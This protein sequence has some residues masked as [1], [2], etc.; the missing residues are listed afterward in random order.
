[1]T[2]TVKERVVLAPNPSPLTGPGTNTILLGEREVAVI[3]P[4]PADPAHL[5]AVLDAVG[6]GRVT[7]ILVT[8]THLDHSEG[9]AAL[10]RAT[11]APILAF[12]GAE[13]GR[14]AAMEHAAAL[15]LASSGE[16]VDS[17][18]A[19]DGTLAD[20]AEINTA[21][22]SLRAIHTPG[23]MGNHLSFASGGTIYCGDVVM[24]WSTTLISP[25][26]GDLTDYFR[27][28]NRLAAES[29]RRLVPA[30]GAPVEAPA[31][32][33]SELAAHRRARTAQVLAALADAPGDAP[34]DAASLAARI[35]D[36]APALLPAATRNVLAH[37]LALSDL[38][39]VR[40]HDD[41][42]RLVWSR[43]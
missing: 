23:H 29:P 6:P 34:G 17:G 15:G 24:G 31:A 28:L 8:H 13:A 4:G 12:G 41:A 9:A 37:L 32:R 1:M 3:D 22:W 39:A 25:P 16:G 38:G 7:H 19:H 42:G 33:L 30:H 10:S 20:G 27:T 36:I 21:E 26:E 11:G 14:S 5:A 2:N 40:W 18:F 43:G 35:Y